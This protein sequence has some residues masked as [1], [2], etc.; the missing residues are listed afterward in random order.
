MRIKLHRAQAQVPRRA[1]KTIFERDLDLCMVIVTSDSIRLARRRLTLLSL[2]LVGGLF[3]QPIQ[4]VLKLRL[5][6]TLTLPARKLET[7][8]PAWSGGSAIRAGNVGC[9][10]IVGGTLLSVTQDVISLVDI[11]HARLR[12]SLFADVGVI[13][14]RELSIRFADIVLRSLTWHF[15]YLVIVFK[16]HGCGSA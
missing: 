3:E 12:I 10:L 1:R 14:A 6:R 11:A 15:Q 5:A 4:K 9:E 16:F 7:A 13:F 2:A 8:L